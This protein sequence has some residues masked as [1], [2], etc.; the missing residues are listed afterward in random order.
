LALEDVQSAM[1]QARFSQFAGNAFPAP[2]CENSDKKL[3]FDELISEPENGTPLAI[4]RPPAKVSPT[5]TSI[6]TWSEISFRRKNNRSL[7]SDHVL[8]SCFCRC[9][10]PTSRR[11]RDRPADKSWHPPR[12]NFGHFPAAERAK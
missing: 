7:H 5:H 8:I 4:T 11:Y 6:N 10:L 12:K 9:V 1:E 2:E 3:L